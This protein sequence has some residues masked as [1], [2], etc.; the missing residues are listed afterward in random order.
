MPGKEQ[1]ITCNGC[2]RTICNKHSV[3]HQKQQ[4]I[5]QLDNIIREYEQSFNEHTFFKNIDQWEKESITKIQITADTGRKDL[6][7]V[8][9]KSKERFSKTYNDIAINLHLSHDTNNYSENELNRSIEQ[10]KQL[11]L[12]IIAP[13]SVK[14]IEN[15]WSIIDLNATQDNNTI[16]DTSN[17]IIQDKFSKV[18]GSTILDEGGSIAKHTSEDWNYEYILGEQLYFHGRHTILF[19]I[20]QSGAPYN[21]FFGCISSQGIQNRICIKSSH[22]AGWFGYNQVYQHGAHNNNPNLHGYSST[23]FATNDILSLTFDCD[24]KQIELYHEDTNKNH[25]LPI[26][27]NK[28]PFPWQ[29]LM[30]LTDKDDCVKILSTNKFHL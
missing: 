8:I 23:E 30:V 18:I 25:I 3:E 24:K 2:Q 28:A 7:H 19:K 16:K 15:E 29:F 10:L 13:I 1:C 20:E 4:L 6:Q 11:Q 26:N 9:E 17:S 27:L 21:I 5:N 14:F 22:T 12:Q